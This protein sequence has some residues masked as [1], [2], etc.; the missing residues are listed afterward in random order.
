MGYSLRAPEGLQG[1]VK[2][3]LGGLYIPKTIQHP[4]NTDRKTLLTEY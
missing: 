1:L 4:A 2:V 3:V